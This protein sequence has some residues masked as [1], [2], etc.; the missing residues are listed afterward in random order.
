MPDKTY[1]D[2]GVPI[3]ASSDYLVLGVPK[4]RL[5]NYARTPARLILR[6]SLVIVE[7]VT[8]EPSGL[9]LYGTSSFWQ[10]YQSEPIASLALNETDDELQVNFREKSYAPPKNLVRAYDISTG[11]E[12]HTSMFTQLKYGIR[13]LRNK[14]VE[15]ATTTEA[16]PLSGESQPN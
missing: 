11:Q 10:P 4:D 14:V 7:I 16:Q 3:S 1:L 2:L 12:A 9:S 5:P 8:P 15:Q 6:D 13:A